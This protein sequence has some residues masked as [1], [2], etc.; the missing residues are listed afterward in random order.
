MIYAQKNCI[1]LLVL[2]IHCLQKWIY[3]SRRLQRREDGVNKLESENSD[4]KKELKNTL[5]NE[6]R[7]QDELSQSD[8]RFTDEISSLSE[9]LGKAFN[10]KTK[11]SEAK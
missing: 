7:L 2:W 10:W 6:S 9:Q 8:V 5:L 4:L 1:P 11:F 3:E